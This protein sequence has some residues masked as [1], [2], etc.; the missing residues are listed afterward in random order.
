MKKV[1]KKKAESS[2]EGKH[3]KLLTIPGHEDLA[4]LQI[5]KK[6]YENMIVVFEDIKLTKTKTKGYLIGFRFSFTICR[7]IAAIS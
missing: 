3:W 7:R 1:T 2:V 5:L 6:P 4:T